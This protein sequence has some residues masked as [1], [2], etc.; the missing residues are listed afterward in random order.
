MKKKNLNLRYIIISCINR[1]EGVDLRLYIQM[2]LHSVLTYF[3]QD[4]HAALFVC[5][6]CPDVFGVTLLNCTR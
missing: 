3:V 4:M 5:T 1:K 2:N 6:Q